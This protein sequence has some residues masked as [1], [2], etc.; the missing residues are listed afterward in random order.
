MLAARRGPAA[1]LCRARPDEVTLHVGQ[2]AQNGNHQPP[3]AGDGIS[4]RLGQ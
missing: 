2:S 1:A 4:P 3:R